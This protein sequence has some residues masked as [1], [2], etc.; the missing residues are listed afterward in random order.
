MCYNNGREFV[1]SICDIYPT[2]LELK[3]E[4]QG[5]HDAK[6][7]NLDITTEEGTFI[8]KL[9]DKRDSILF[10]IVRIPHIESNIPQNVFHSAIKGE[11]L[12]IARSTLCLRDSITKAKE[13]LEQMKQQRFKKNNISSSRDFPAFVY[14]MSGPPK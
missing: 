14:F 10:S 1:R 2:E 9:S 13:L 5:D 4:H 3:V 8:Y 7:L 12:R 11:C 6:F